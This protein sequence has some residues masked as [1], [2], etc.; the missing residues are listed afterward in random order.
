MWLSEAGEERIA[1]LA[2]EG[3]GR[4]TRV[5]LDDRQPG[6]MDQIGPR[7]SLPSNYGTL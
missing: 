3:S 4:M 5:L 1:C 2:R 7:A 6:P